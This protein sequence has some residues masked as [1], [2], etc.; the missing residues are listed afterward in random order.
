MTYNIEST[1]VD[2]PVTIDGN[3]GNDMFNVSPMAR[4]LDNLDGTL[5]VLDA[6]GVNTLNVND[7]NNPNPDTYTMTLFTVSRTNSASIN[8]AF[9]GTDVNLNAG[10]GNNIF[11]VASTPFA[12]VTFHGGA[13]LDTLVAPNFSSTFDITGVNSGTLDTNLSFSFVENLRGNTGDDEFKFGALG[14]ISG[15]VDGQ[16]APTRSTI[17]R[18]P[19][20][21]SSTC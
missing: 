11:E 14:F 8:Y 7:Q 12:D 9:L 21:S 5:S 6:D 4:N 17:R 15:T 13:G 18:G 16:G 1:A 20:P 10:T 3:T 19:P 2:N